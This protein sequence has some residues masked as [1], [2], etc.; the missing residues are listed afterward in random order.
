MRRRPFMRE[1]LIE[2]MG[3]AISTVTAG[4]ARG[5]LGH[6]GYPSAGRLL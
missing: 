4:D 3:V 1:A 2:V 5:F 6:C